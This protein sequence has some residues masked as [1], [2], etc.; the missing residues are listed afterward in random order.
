MLMA[1]A[2]T[3]V[4][5]Y[6]PEDRLTNKDLEKM[7]DTSDEWIRTRTG[8]EERRILKDPTKATSDM[9]AEAVRALCSKSGLDP[10]DIDLIVCATVTPDMLFPSTANLIGHKVGATKAWGFDLSAACSGFLFALKT[11]AQFV[12]NGTAKNVVVVGADKMSS[13]VDYT[14]RTT[15]VLFGDAAAAARQMRAPAPDSLVLWRHCQCGV[16]LDADPYP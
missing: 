8:I 11:A 14:D 10:T 12:E 1:A 16:A 5:G 13:I 6:L 2:I 15:C 7:V 4:A 3:S 9:G